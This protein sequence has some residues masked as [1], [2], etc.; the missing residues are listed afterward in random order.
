MAAALMVAAG[1]GHAD[2]LALLLGAGADQSA[3]GGVQFRFCDI[4]ISYMRLYFALQYSFVIANHK[5]I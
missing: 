3:K 1:D 5:S 2:C 4:T